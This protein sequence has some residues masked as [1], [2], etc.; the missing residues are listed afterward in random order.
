MPLEGKEEAF[1]EL[2]AFIASDWG[3]TC[4][5]FGDVVMGVIVPQ[6]MEETPVDK[7][8]LL[9]SVPATSFVEVTPKDCTAFVGAGGAAS[10]YARRQHED[11]TYHH[12]VGKAKFIED[13]VRRIAPEVP[14]LVAARKGSPQ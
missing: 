10:A 4:Q 6:C 8:I 9:Q 3:Q 14:A 11:L 13:P 12:T 1:R 5:A 2:D 7:G